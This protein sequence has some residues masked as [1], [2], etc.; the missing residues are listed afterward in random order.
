M[1]TSYPVGIVIIV[2]VLTGMLFGGM[3]AS[4]VGI[5]RAQFN[6]NE[7]ITSLMMNYIAGILL[8]YLIFNSSSYWR[9]PRSA[10]FPSGKPLE[11]R[12]HWPTYE[13]FGVSIA[14][15]IL[16]AVLAA[17]VL[18]VIYK[19]SRLGFEIGIIAVVVIIA[20]SGRAIFCISDTK[21]FAFASR[22]TITAMPKPRA[23][24]LRI[25]KKSSKTSL[26]IV[27]TTLI[28]RI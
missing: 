1:G 6:T 3:Y 16:L 15:G 17:V 21:V 18:W 8:N 22:A 2:M 26:F 7:I 4:I 9:D 20:A 24:R 25:E 5:L 27:C 19:R 28:A 12:T 23:P 13:V 10:G 11:K 14:F